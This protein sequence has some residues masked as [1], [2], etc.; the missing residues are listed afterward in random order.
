MN[1]NCLRTRVFNSS[2]RL[3]AG[4]VCAAGERLWLALQTLDA[5][6]AAGSPESQDS[7]LPALTWFYTRKSIAR[8]SSVKEEKMTKLLVWL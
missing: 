4:R 5:H 8:K 1:L 3:L 2:E 7:P 6:G